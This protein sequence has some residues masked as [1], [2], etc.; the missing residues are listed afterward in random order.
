[1]KLVIKAICGEVVLDE[2]EDI[3]VLHALSFKEPGAAEN[4]AWTDRE[5][6]PERYRTEL[7]LSIRRE[8]YRGVFKP[9]KKYTITVTESEEQ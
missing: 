1:M 7:K 3:H 9:G 8:K 5:I 2:N 6:R 4:A